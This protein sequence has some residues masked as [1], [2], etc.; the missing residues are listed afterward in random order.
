[1][2]ISEKFERMSKTKKIRRYLKFQ[3]LIQESISSQGHSHRFNCPFK[4]KYASLRALHCK[5]SGS[6]SNERNSA[7]INWFSIQN[8]GPFKIPDI[9]RTSS[10]NCCVKGSPLRSSPSLEKSACGLEFLLAAQALSAFLSDENSIHLQIC[11]TP[12]EQLG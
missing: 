4:N 9:S 3:K 12:A 7:N 10:S 5:V 11:C 6:G 1:M 2:R 8:D